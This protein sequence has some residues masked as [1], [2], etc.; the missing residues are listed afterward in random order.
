VL[1]H[2]AARPLVPP[3]VVDA[4]LEATRIHGAAIPALVV[5]D[6]VKEVDAAGT[7]A[8][9]LDR[10]AVRLAQTPQGSRVDWLLGALELAQRDDFAFSDEAG[11]LQHAGRSVRVVAGDARNFKITTR[12]DID[13]ARRA[14][15]GSATRLRVGTGYDVHRF[16]T[17]GT[18]VLGGVEFPGEPPLEGHSDADVV[19]HAVMDALLGAAC[20]GDIGFH[21]PPS[22]L[23]YRGASSTGLATQVADLVRDSGFCVV[24]V[25]LTVLA[26]R[27]KIGPRVPQMRA[28]I[29]SCL[30]LETDRVAV[31]ATTLE[32]LG[33]LGR[34][35]GIAC[36][37]VALLEA[38]A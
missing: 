34:A 16:G 1:V 10:E 23:R 19:L 26:E 13:R 36:Q 20:L 28:A 29:A 30:R 38:D 25:D 21:F 24:N 17:E 33:A 22:D 14:L 8:R 18:L 35:E 32:G 5:Q 31:K 7:V 6:T 2:D 37:A 11:A 9:T 4:V 27:P 15:G 3:A 12:E